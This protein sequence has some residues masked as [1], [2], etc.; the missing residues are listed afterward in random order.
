MGLLTASDSRSPPWPPVVGQRAPRVVLRSASSGRTQRDPR[1]LLAAALIIGAV[2]AMVSGR[3]REVEE[4][5]PSPEVA[6]GPRA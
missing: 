4:I 2:G 5:G 3:P 1:T 6:A